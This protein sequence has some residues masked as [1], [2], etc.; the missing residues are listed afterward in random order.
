MAQ[1]Y[2]V[3]AGPDWWVLAGALD[4]RVQQ[5][6]DS[7][8]GLEPRTEDQQLRVL[9]EVLRTL[10]EQRTLLHCGINAVLCQ[11]GAARV[12]SPVEVH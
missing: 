6:L 1:T 5:L 9:A 12:T 8:E 11:E 7:L 3:T 4:R 2:P 10:D